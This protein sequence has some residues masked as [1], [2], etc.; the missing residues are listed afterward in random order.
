[1][2]PQKV[3][4]KVTEAL[5]A[6]VMESLDRKL[7][8]LP[9]EAVL[10]SL[11]NQA[12]TAFVGLLSALDVS[13]NDFKIKLGDQLDKLPS[14]S[15]PLEL[16]QLR[17]TNQLVSVLQEAEKQASDLE[18]DFV[19]TEHVLLAAVKQNPDHEILKTISHQSVK[20]KIEDVRGDMKVTDQNPENK[21]KT[22]DKFGQ[23]FTLMAKDGDLDP[24]I[25]RDEEIR[26]IM[27]VLSRRTKNN[28]VL[29]GEPG[30]GK[31]AIVEGLAQ[32]IVNGDVP[33][34]LK[35][36][37]IIGLEMGSLLA[38]AKFRGEF[39]ERLKS[40]LDEV[41]KSDGEI[42]LFIDELHTVVGAGKAEGAVDAANMLKPLLARGKLHLIGA[43][44][45]NE[46]RK[47][48]EK[49]AALERRF[50]PVSVEEPSTEDAITI[51]RGLQEKYEVHHGVSISDQAIVAAVKLSERYISDRFLPDKAVDLIDEATSALK[52]EIESMPT[53]LDR[54]KRKVTRLEIE[55]AAIKKDRSKSAKARSTSIK[56]EIA[57][58]NESVKGLEAQWQNEKGL[59]AQINKN[60][61][62]VDSLKVAAEQA[63]REGDL[64]KAG[65]IRYSKLPKLEDSIKKTRSKLK[66]LDPKR[67]LLRQQVTEED[68]SK[69]VAR[70][71]AIPVDRLLESESHKLANLEKQLGKRVIG[72]RDAIKAVSNAIRRARAGIG[73][74]NKPIGSFMFFGPTGVGKTEL[75]KAL[76]EQLFDDERAIVRLDMS[77]YMERHSI[78]R[79]IGSPP[80]YV[81]HEEGGQL[82]EAIRRRPYAVILLDEIEKAHP[83]V[84]NTLL[85]VLDEGR[86]TD[87]Q[88]RTVNFTNTVVIMTSNL[89]SDLIQAWDGKNPSKLEKD[90]MTAVKQAFR[91]EF[92]NRV[93]DIVIF[94]RISD[95]NMHEIVDIQLDRIVDS[96]RENKGI[97][98]TFDDQARQLLAKQ[99]YDPVFGARPLQRLIQKTVL[100]PLA[101]DII[102]QDK[103]PK[104]V[105]VT[106][107]DSQ[108]K[109]TT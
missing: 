49:D 105:T 82:T 14:S 83:D 103:Q 84:F 20:D 9:L 34:T 74:P 104:K 58:L 11:A 22:L 93:D 44:T 75:S 52:I 67:R 21:M 43:T 18:D 98:I 66:E 64:T 41:V 54:L 4:Q 53:E 63:E 47:H 23:D 94:H 97:E 42:V 35:N 107:K 71:T 56:K 91:P 36:K 60:S 31:T 96:L 8:A 78:A 16:D 24:V 51:L 17:P 85:Q 29:I 7:T 55:L 73:D 87:G 76:A 33:S 109:I 39:E 89:G 102:S 86:L 92:I 81:G 1:M 12:D 45:I 77:E 13:L 37:R 106:V 10:L 65:E 25:G 59:I 30:V 19:S 15:K 32:R 2:N 46:F 80:G 26:R 95:E 79:M 101:L 5:N 48:I 70:W 108:L 3:T 50:Q 38:G 90:I 72:Q 68:I 69:V 61:E 6:A 88:G 62:E 100:D 28:P 57:E 99:G 40:V 27:Q